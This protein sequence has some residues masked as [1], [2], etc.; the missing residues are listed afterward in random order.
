MSNRGGLYETID[1]VSAR[2]RELRQTPMWAHLISAMLELVLEQ[3]PSRGG[4]ILSELYM[5]LQDRILPATIDENGQKSGL[6]GAA[7]DSAVASFDRFLRLTKT[8]KPFQDRVLAWIASQPNDVTPDSTLGEWLAVLRRNGIGLENFLDEKPWPTRTLPEPGL[9]KNWE[10]ELN[11]LVGLEVVKEQ[12]R[13][14]RSFL[15]VR[16]LREANKLKVGQFTHHQAFLGNP[17]TGKTSV[18]R[19]LAA[20]YRDL[21]ILRTGHLV[22]VDRSHLVGRYVGATEAVTTAVIKRA[23][24]GVLFIDE[25]YSLVAGDSEDFGRVALDL[26]V[27]AMED[28]RHDLIV[29]V[30]GYEEQMQEFL[31]TN[32][33]LVSRIPRRIVFPDYSEAELIKIFQLMV[34]NLD[35]SVES[36]TLTAIGAKLQSIRERDTKRFGNA[37]EVRNLWEALQMN[38]ASRLVRR[39]AGDVSRITIEDLNRITEEDLVSM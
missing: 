26:L 4:G 34:G 17:G 23:L 15:L 28:H 31:N 12:V 7:I 24:G 11:D 27:K 36:S 2:A 1:H 39:Y 22:E 9:T 25:A 35:Y 10:D 29:I 37:R 16:R 13:D 19:I 8:D 18:A 14:L 30:A 38:Q 5:D 33:G 3:E 21:G 6:A 32:P 20:I